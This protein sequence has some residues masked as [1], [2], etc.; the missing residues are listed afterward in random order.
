[1][2]SDR[3]RVNYAELRGT[4]IVVLELLRYKPTVKG[5]TGTLSPQPPRNTI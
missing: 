2:T 3:T 5:P 4:I 1:M